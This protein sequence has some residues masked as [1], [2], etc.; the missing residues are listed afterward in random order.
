MAYPWEDDAAARAPVPGR[1][2]WETDSDEAPGGPE[3]DSDVEGAA[4]PD[5]PE[6]L[7][8]DHLCQLYLTRKMTAKDF[9]VTMYFAGLSGKAGSKME[10]CGR[11][12]MRPDAPSGHYTRHLDKALSLKTGGTPGYAF[13]VP[14]SRMGRTIGRTPVSLF[15][16]PPTRCWTTL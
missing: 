3:S 13:T 14:G 2:P 11:L 7:L 1:Y 15:V 12:G 8:I 6:D 10:N 5:S 16:I 9:C 4:Q